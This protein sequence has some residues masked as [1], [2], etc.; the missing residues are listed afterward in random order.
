MGTDTAMPSGILWIAI[1]TAIVIPSAIFPVAALK[2]VTMPSG[3]LWMAIPI[4]VRTPD[5][6]RNDFDGIVSCGGKP[7]IV[8]YAF[9]P[10]VLGAFAM[11]SSSYS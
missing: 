9:S 1:A 8:L 7:D 10:I 11:R 3:K 2:K 5:L 4:A 6:M